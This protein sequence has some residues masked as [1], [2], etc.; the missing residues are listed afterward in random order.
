MAR[1]DGRNPNQLRDIQIQANHFRKNDV[2]IA[3]GATKVLCY[4][5]IEER[6][7]PWLMGSGS[8][9]LSA[10]Y[11]MLPS[12]GSPRHAR[13]RPYASGRTQE[14]QRLI[15]RSLRAALYLVNLPPLTFH[16]DCDVT[17]ADGGTRTACITGGMVALANLVHQE[18]HR[19]TRGPAVKCLVAAISAG[20]VDGN[21]MLDLN[22]VE[23]RDAEVDANLIG[24]STGGF[25]EVQA[26]NEHGDFTREQLDAILDL[27]IPAHNQLYDM[28]RENIALKGL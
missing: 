21:A 17:V 24:L 5:S 22:Y 10:E 4:A 2:L 8:G 7:P 3:F 28:Q 12:S 15:G 11:N 19:F 27:A 18:N 6:V 26:T 16:V 14:I 1:I 25:A 9:W 13:E 20:M 23:D